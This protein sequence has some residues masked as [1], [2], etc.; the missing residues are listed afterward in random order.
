MSKG[1]DQQR[2]TSEERANLVAYLDGELNEAESRAIA[3]KLTLSVTARRESEVLQ[4]TW[5]LLEHLP[6]PRASESLTQRTLTE[7]GRIDLAGNS[8]FSS[9]S[10][11]LRHARSLATVLLASAACF[12][13]GFL[14][15]R[16][17][18]PDPTARLVRDLPI[19]E[20]LDEYRNVGTIEF[21]ERLDK[22]PEFSNDPH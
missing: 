18:W 15:V 16:W 5:E 2:L 12:V 21:L 8:L 14:L 1:A 7:I 22:S 17:V 11:T 4:K 3:T 10:K 13:L 19:A 9:A 20:H 6:M